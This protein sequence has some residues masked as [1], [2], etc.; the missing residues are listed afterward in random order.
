MNAFYHCC[1]VG[2]GA[3]IE[4]RFRFLAA[5]SGATVRGKR[6]SYRE[7]LLQI[8]DRSVAAPGRGGVSCTPRQVFLCLSRMTSSRTT[9][10]SFSHSQHNVT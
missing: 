8:R 6:P 7:A 1:A 2:V 9:C 3:Q 10:P 5:D 4:S